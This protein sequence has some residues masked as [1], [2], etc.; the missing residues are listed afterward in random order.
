MIASPWPDHL[1]GLQEYLDLP[2]D[3]S[4]HYELAEGILQV[5]PR[6]V[7]KHQWVSKRLSRQLDDQLPGEWSTT[8]EVDVVVDARY[9]VKVRAPD[10]VVISVDRAR[11]EPKNLNASDVLLA[12]EVVSPG[13]RRTDNVSKLNEYA[14]AGIPHYWIIHTEPEATLTAYELIDTDYRLVETAT[15]AFTAV[16]PFP[17]T[18]DLTSLTGV[19]TPRS[20]PGDEVFPASLTRR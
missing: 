2:E 14:D 18:V 7:L 1:L 11:E 15:D 9:P 4:R 20:G 17:L 6:P 19:L 10:L 8:H 5:S 12:V 3:T 13:S 16:R